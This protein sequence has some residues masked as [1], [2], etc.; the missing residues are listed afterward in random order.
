MF[1]G[2]VLVTACRAGARS[3][4]GHVPLSL[5]LLYMTEHV[6]SESNLVSDTK[7]SDWDVRQLSPVFVPECYSTDFHD[8]QEADDS[9]ALVVVAVLASMCRVP[10]VRRAAWGLCCERCGLQPTGLWA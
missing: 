5:A 7:L 3:M 10:S 2:H 6:E 9:S 1:G 4:I 8:R